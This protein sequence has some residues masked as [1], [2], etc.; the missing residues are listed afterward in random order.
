MLTGR[1]M[2]RIF[3]FFILTILLISGCSENLPADSSREIAQG[4]VIGI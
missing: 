1:G 2:T 4:Q 3:S